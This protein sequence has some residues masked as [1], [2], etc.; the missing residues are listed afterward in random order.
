MR[1]RIPSNGHGDS[2]GKVSVTEIQP[3]FAIFLA[4]RDEPPDTE[5]LPVAIA[6]VLIRWIDERKVTVRHTLPIIKNGNMVY[7]FVWYDPP[8]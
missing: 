3:G 5:E 1:F 6:D 4:N 7:L 2:K 8:G